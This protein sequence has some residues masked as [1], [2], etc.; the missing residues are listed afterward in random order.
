MK[1]T[2]LTYL[3]SCLAIGVFAGCIKSKEN[4]N[5]A[6]DLINSPLGYWATEDSKLGQI[7]L[8]I[9]TD[10]YKKCIIALDKKIVEEEGTVQIDGNR[11]TYKNKDS[12]NE[13][14]ATYHSDNNSLTEDQPIQLKYVRADDNKVKDLNN[15]GC[16]L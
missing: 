8:K 9:D 7:G 2:R 4:T 14:S 12:M 15:K 10:D 5:K 13:T 1:V 11:I 6:N 3:I 16:H